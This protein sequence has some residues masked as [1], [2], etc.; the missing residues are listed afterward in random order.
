MK[1]HYSLLTFAGGL[2]LL[3]IQLLALVFKFVTGD[4]YDTEIVFAVAKDNSLEAFISEFW[5]GVIGS[6]MLIVLFIRRIS[7]GPEAMLT[8]VGVLLWVIQILS[9]YESQMLSSFILSYLIGIIGVIL[10][11]IAALYDAYVTK[12]KSSDDTDMDK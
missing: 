8:L 3:V 11:G 6:I 12:S 4:D 5:S 10:V 1:K 7:K 9:M 2:L